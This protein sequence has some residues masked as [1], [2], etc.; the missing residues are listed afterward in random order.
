MNE[1]KKAIMEAAVKLF[2]QKGYNTT[3]VQEI[4]DSCGISKGAFYLHFRSKEALMLSIF[5]FYSENVQQK[6]AEIEHADLS[7]REKLVQQIEVHL[8]EVLARK[9]L[10]VLQF[11]EQMLYLNQEMEEFF[12]ELHVKKEKW[13]AT[14]FMTMY[15][16]GVL[17]YMLICPVYL[18]EC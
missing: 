7:S 4:A 13:H 15:G 14:R 8:Q 9:E 10:F 18:M 12:K 2:A 6:M 3:S 16:E 17:L 5:Q 1:K 11:R